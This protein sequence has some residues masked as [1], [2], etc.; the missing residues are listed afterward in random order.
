[1]KKQILLG[2][3]SKAQVGKDFAAI[4]LRQYF[5]VERIAFADALKHD[6]ANLFS[7]NNLDFH[8]L[9]KDLKTKEMIR[10]LMTAYGDVMRAFDPNIWVD[11]ALKGKELTHE[12]TII[13][14][15]RFPNEVQAIKK[16]GGYYI[17]I[18]TDT[19][20]ANATEA[21]YSPI[22]RTYADCGVRNNFDSKFIP[23]MVTLVNRLFDNHEDSKN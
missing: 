13:T 20:P 15:V 6:L 8:E 18:T 4:G 10:P 9:C 12:L 17:D 7:D 2:L 14:D 11:K 5:D 3:G 1:M 22:M 23:D 21:Y 16:L 19:P